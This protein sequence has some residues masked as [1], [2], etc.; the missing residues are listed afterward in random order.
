M[1]MPPRVFLSIRKHKQAEWSQDKELLL[2]PKGQFRGEPLSVNE[3]E[4]IQFRFESFDPNDRMLVEKFDTESLE[5]IKPGGSI[6]ITKQGDSDEMLVPGDYPVLV[7]TASGGFESLYRIEPKNMN[8]N[9]LLNLRSYLEMKLTGLSFDLLKRRSGTFV[10]ENDQI[11][12]ALKIYQ[13]IQKSFNKL[14]HNLNGIVANPIRDVLQVYGP[15]N[16]SRKPDAKSQRWLSKRGSAK[17]TNF[18]M[19]TYFY[20]KHTHLTEDILEN[21]WVKY[22][23]K[24]TK[25]ALKQL[26]V[27]FERSRSDQKS[28][29]NKKRSEVVSYQGRRARIGSAFGYDSRKWEL[30]K[31]ISQGEKDILHLE[32]GLE[33]I[34]NNLFELNKMVTHFSRYEQDECLSKVSDRLIHKK[35]TLRLLKDSRYAGIYRFYQSLNTLQKK[36]ISVKQVVFPYKKTSLLFEYFVL[37]LI[38]ESLEENRFSWSGGW[39]ADESD[40][41]TMIGGLTSETVLRFERNNGEFYIELA[42]DTQILD[43]IDETISHFKANINRAPD[44]RISLYKND[45][46]FLNT[47]IVDAKYR[48]YSYLWDE[49]ED[50]DVMK[51]LS[52]YLRIWHYDVNKPVRYRLNRSAVSK[53]VAVY[54]KQQGFNPF[55]EKNDKTLAFVQVEPTDPVSGKRSYGFDKL[56]ELIC[57]FLESSLETEELHMGVT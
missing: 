8:W 26:Q 46:E 50:N 20:E 13:H 19:P 55:F 28:K 27:M 22:V 41:A 29:I 10:D 21:Q 34:D 49:H 2:H 38:I 6:L 5:E 7:E 17:N 3:F 32:K 57:E 53:V 31:L 42:Y 51:Q 39:L 11:P 36:D 37:C 40:P 52:D 14:R 56:N 47:L 23:L 30:N 43:P 35:P 24:K 1:T 48:H 18:L 45:G 54:P 16:F 25:L 12:H 15:R 4:G 9:Q 44:F 33:K